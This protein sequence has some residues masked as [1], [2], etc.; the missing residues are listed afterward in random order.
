MCAPYSLATLIMQTRLSR[1]TIARMKMQTGAVSST[2]WSTRWSLPQASRAISPS[3][4]AP[5]DAYLRSQ[6]V[7]WATTLILMR[8]ADN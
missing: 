3:F 2:R 7:A 1:P 8:K 4:V 6:E 5:F